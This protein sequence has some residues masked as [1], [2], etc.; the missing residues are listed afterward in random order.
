MTK[1]LMNAS[2]LAAFIAAHEIAA[3]IILLA[4]HTPTVEAAARALDVP[5]ARIA[6]SILFLA[7]DS[8][9][10]VVANGTHRIDYKRLAGTLGL[11]RKK[12]RM[13]DSQQVMSIAGYAVGAMPPFGHTARLRTLIDR[14]MFDQPQVYAGGGEINAMLRVT[15]E[16]IRRVAGAEPADVVEAN[17]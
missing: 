3:E 14:R 10:L 8:P 7:G 15:P 17:V 11:S 1:I 12:I 13:A 5:V 6:K 2:D 4:E 16:E 9:V